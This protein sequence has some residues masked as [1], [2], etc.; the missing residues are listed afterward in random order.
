MQWKA[1][2]VAL[3][4]AAERGAGQGTT[5]MMRFGCSQLVV[6]RIDPLVNPGQAPS[7]HLHQIVGGNSFNV[8][9]DPATHDLPTAS[10][11]TS[12]TFS[13]D[14]SNYWTAVLFFRARN[15]TFK[16]VPQQQ[17]IGLSGNAGITVYYIP[18]ATGKST[19][20]AF[21]PGFRMLV[22][23]AGRKSSTTPAPHKVCHRC[24]P[25]SGDK[26][27]INCGSPDAQTLPKDFCAGGIRS[28]TT[29][30]TCWDGKNTDSP[31]HM[32]HVAYATGAAVNDVG[33]TGK[34]PASH[35]VAIPQVMYEVRWQT[36]LFPKSEW[37]ADGSQPFVWSTGDKNGYSQHGDYVFGWKGDSLQRALDARCTG[38]TCKE[39]KTQTVAEAD[40]CTR[41]QTV[42]EDVN[43]W[44]TSLPGDVMVM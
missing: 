3:L 35:P 26:S 42:R 33:P 9:M 39:L 5:P 10:T 32:S 18:P 40:K 31:D 2:T 22:G 30:P 17:E 27:N 36:E 38:D 23:D 13:E 25:K 1:I 7:P 28:I 16:R 29:F 14:F 15:G 12:C 43:G 6:D 44:L 37:P 24:M 21:K 4:A 11:C 8:S 41:A 34:C 20:T 19:V